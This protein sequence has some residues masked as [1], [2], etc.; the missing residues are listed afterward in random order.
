MAAAAPRTGEVIFSDTSCDL[1][2]VSASSED[3]RSGLSEE[4]SEEHK[5]EPPREKWHERVEDAVAPGPT[6]K[7]QSK[8][9]KKAK[10]VDLGMF[11]LVSFAGGVATYDMRK[12][13]GY[14][15]RMSDEGAE[16]CSQPPELMTL[17]GLAWD[18]QTG[19]LVIGSLTHDQTG[20][21]A[22]VKFDE[23]T[24]K[25]VAVSQQYVLMAQFIME[26]R[27]GRVGMGMLPASVFSV[28]R[29]FCKAV[30]D[31]R[32]ALKFPRGLQ[33]ERRTMF[34]PL[35]NRVSLKKRKADYVEPGP[36]TCKAMQHKA[37]ATMLPGRSIVAYARANT[38][39][40]G[41][42]Y[43][44]HRSGPT[45]YHVANPRAV[46]RSMPLSRGSIAAT[47]VAVEVA[48]LETKSKSKTKRK[49]SGPG[50]TRG[51][52]TGN[53][54][55]DGLPEICYPVPMRVAAVLYDKQYMCA[56]CAK[57][58]VSRH[59]DPQFSWTIQEVQ[60]RMGADSDFS[61]TWCTT[62]QKMTITIV[63]ALA[64]SAPTAQYVSKNR[65]RLRRTGTVARGAAIYVLLS[66]VRASGAT[67]HLK[68]LIATIYADQPAIAAG[69]LAAFGTRSWRENLN[70]DLTKL[71]RD[72]ETA[73]TV[74][75]Y[76]R[77]RY[78]KALPRM[79]SRAIERTVQTDFICVLKPGYK[80]TPKS[81]SRW[82]VIENENESSP[83]ST[84]VC[85][86]MWA[87]LQAIQRG[88][89]VTIQLTPPMKPNQLCPPVVGMIAH[90]ADEPVTCGAPF[91]AVF[92]GEYI[93]PF[94]VFR[95]MQNRII[96]LGTNDPTRFAPL[97]IYGNW[98]QAMARPEITVPTIDGSKFTL[99]T[100]LF[101]DELCRLSIKYQFPSL[102]VVLNS[103][104]ADFA[105][106]PMEQADS[107][108]ESFREHK[109]MIKAVE[110][111]AEAMTAR[112]SEDNGV[113]TVERIMAVV[114]DCRA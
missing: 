26:Q 114:C 15:L 59:A 54:M 18:S 58:N 65:A 37:P 91:P 88:W 99:R 72:Q 74:A 31:E 43:K 62:A 105:E 102:K 11:G 64:V 104:H 79:F 20:V 36:G 112:Y 90:A 92:N 83:A 12:R 94:T 87:V 6:L 77:F 66:K 67:G 96:A 9:N 42:E 70:G 3:S 68:S 39:V 93:T 46:A 57:R 25:I 98:P 89:P 97:V 23:G 55:D 52:I 33:P 8:P 113:A 53:V 14:G 28:F 69:V 48:A 19:R 60:R 80:V 17:P 29:P 103:K 85:Y 7:P 100:G 5:D 41:N 45:T 10:A 35:M 95:E 4:L 32:T 27:P 78:P 16:E 22:N 107:V 34:H 81:I 84:F 76:S 71:L 49:G 40:F 13:N 38:S 50:P 110:K 82:V 109:Q 61:R 75:E 63:A 30:H 86:E 111:D 106:Y 51:H 101:F 56:Q 1:E 2:S 73:V 24:G 21:F 108:R 47:A 44:R